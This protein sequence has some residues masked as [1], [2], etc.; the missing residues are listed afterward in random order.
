MHKTFEPII[1][2]GKASIHVDTDIFGKVTTVNMP[3]R[4][5]IIGGEYHCCLLKKHLADSIGDNMY[6]KDLYLDHILLGKYEAKL[7]KSFPKCFRQ[8]YHRDILGWADNFR[9]LG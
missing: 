2:D 6:I 9:F 8:S 1:D 7:R 4:H 3:Q 5:I